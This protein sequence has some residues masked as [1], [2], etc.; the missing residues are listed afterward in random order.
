MIDELK[1]LTALADLKTMTRAATYLRVSQSTISKR[2]QTLEDLSQ[3]KLTQPVGRRVELTDFGRQLAEAAPKVL[4]ELEF[5]FLP[6]PSKSNFMP[7]LRI[8]IGESILTSSVARSVVRFEEVMPE[9]T[10]EVHAH[11]AQVLIDKVSSGELHIGLG[12]K[13]D[14]TAEGLHF[15]ELAKEQFVIIPS[16][17]KPFKHNYK[18]P[19]DLVTIEESAHSWKQIRVEAGKLKFRPVRR[20]ESFFAAAQ[21]AINGFGHGFVPRGTAE[22]LGIINRCEK[23][24]NGRKIY[25]SIGIFGRKRI[26]GRYEI[27]VLKKILIKRM[28]R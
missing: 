18:N 17:L 7:K 14:M 24:F 26:L 6:H 5:L 3:Q 1:T 25:R 8:G 4:L 15:E 2:I 13:R 22:A 27:D 19:L 28:R 23:S 12:S 9:V 11:R 10:L 16:G 21:L 20:L